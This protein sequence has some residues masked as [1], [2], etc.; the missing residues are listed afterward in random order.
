[1]FQVFQTP[2]KTQQGVMILV[3]RNYFDHFQKIYQDLH[4]QFTIAI[5]FIKNLP[6]DKQIDIIVIGHYSQQTEQERATDELR[7]FSENIQRDYPGVR[8]VVMGD[9]NRHPDSTRSLTQ[10]VNLSI[11]EPTIQNGFYTYKRG[12]TQS[13]IDFIASDG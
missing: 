8:L 13:W 2:L 1:M 5:R 9:F 4:S 12:V 10:S 3:R 11:S 6:D 7:F